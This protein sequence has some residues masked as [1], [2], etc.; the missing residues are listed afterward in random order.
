MHRPRSAIAASL[1]LLVAA[2]CSRITAATV[3]STGE[4]ANFGVS[5]GPT[6]STNGR[7][8]AYDSE[9]TNLVPGDTNGSADV[10]VHDERTGR[11]ERVSVAPDGTQGNGERCGPS[12]HL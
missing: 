7:F 8:V 6:L 9:A 2:G 10:F 1:L 5:S 4:Q 3:S 12:Y 11:T